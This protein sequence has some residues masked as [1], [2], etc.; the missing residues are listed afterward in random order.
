MQLQAQRKEKQKNAH[1]NH[2]VTYINDQLLSWM[3][4]QNDNLDIYLLH[5]CIPFFFILHVDVV[6]NIK[7]VVTW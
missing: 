1:V 2:H 3:Y 4:K 7:E 5:Q 6:W